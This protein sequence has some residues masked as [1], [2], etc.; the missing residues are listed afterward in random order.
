M[1]KKIFIIL[2][3]AVM[4]ATAAACAGGDKKDDT[5]KTETDDTGS[6]SESDSKTEADSDKDDK[7]RTEV[8]SQAEQVEYDVN[9]C[10][11]LGDYSA[12]KVSLPNSYKVTKKQIE[13]YANNMA[14]YYAQPVYKDTKKKKVEEGDTVNIDYVGKR[15]GE[16]FDGGTASGYNLTIGSH[17]FIDGFEEGLVGKKVGETVD[18][19][20]TFPE[21]YQNQEM[22]GVDVVFTVTIN[23]IVEVDETAEFELNDEFVKQYFQ[24][25]TVEDYMKEVKSYLKTTN[26]S[27]KTMDT[28]QAVIDQL[29]EICEV[30]LPQEL[31]DACMADQM[32]VFANQH[33]GGENNEDGIT[34][35]M[36]LKDNYNGLTVEDFKQDFSKD[37]ES[38]LK[39]ELILEAIAAKE[40]IE[41]DEEAFKEYVENQMSANGYTT[42]EDFYAA[43]SVNAAYGEKYEKK[44]YVC[45]RALDQVIESASIKYGVTPEE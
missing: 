42:E 10:V 40:G 38:N 26:E 41:L 22:A 4:A 45:N 24:F 17:S 20:L 34:L 18:L 15:D 21:N 14:Q 16:A 44:I 31:L 3:A 12:L 7:D 30:N 13:D 29:Q 6:G 27:N 32:I 39:T 36:Y 33:Y 19:D 11:K 35:E 28:R 37:V 5:T 23:K 8:A 43:N 25:D 2:L 1:K 9:E